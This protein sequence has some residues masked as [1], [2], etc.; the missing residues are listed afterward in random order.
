MVWLWSRQLSRDLFRDAGLAD[1][2]EILNII[3]ETANV[4]LHINKEEVVHII[5][6]FTK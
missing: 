5:K 2:R 3:S 6:L 1:L 4:T